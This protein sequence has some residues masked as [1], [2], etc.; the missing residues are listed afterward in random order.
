MPIFTIL[1]HFLRF[2]S[3]LRPIFTTP[4]FLYPGAPGLTIPQTQKPEHGHKRH[5][6]MPKLN[7]NA[8]KSLQKL[9]IQ[10]KNIV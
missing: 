4:S 10:Q 5:F 2:L 9:K 8:E 7:K 3:L 6:E 1:A